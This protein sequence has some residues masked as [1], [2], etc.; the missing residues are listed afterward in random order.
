DGGDDVDRP[1]DRAD[2]HQVNGEDEIGDA[3]RRVCRGERGVEGPAKIGSAARREQGR[4]QQQ[5]R[6]REEPETEVVHARQRHVRCAD[7]QR[8]HPVRQPDEGRHDRTEHHHQPV[9]GGHL[10][11]ECWLHDLQT[12][13][14]Q[15]GTDH[16]GE[17]AAEQE[18]AEAE[19]QVQ[20][21][22]VLVVMSCLLRK[23][24]A[25]L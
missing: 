14:E 13:L 17:R 20:R 18:H 3:F 5:E 10:V 12:G 2:P 24:R 23:S 1:H 11:K 7:H 9:H 15:F 25:K 4:H 22:D 21:A 6:R 19:P 16:H 8:D